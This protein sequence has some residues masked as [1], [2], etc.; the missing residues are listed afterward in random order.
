M[1]ARHLQS[2]QQLKAL[3]EVM[4]MA[5]LDHPHVCRYLQSW[6]VPYVRSKLYVACFC[7]GLTTDNPSHRFG[8]AL[9]T[10]QHILIRPTSVLLRFTLLNTS[11]V[12][13]GVK[14]DP[15]HTIPFPSRACTKDPTRSLH[16]HGLLRHHYEKTFCAYDYCS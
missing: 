8:S 2:P 1:S 5:K 7:C 9:T 11:T 4:I 13:A 15:R 3:R 6:Y 14:L 16:H 10:L 12:A